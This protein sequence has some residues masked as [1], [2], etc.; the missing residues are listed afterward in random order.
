MMEKG[1]I[2]RTAAPLRWGDGA[3]LVDMVTK[4]AYREGFG[5]ELAEGS[6]RL[7]EKYGYPEYSM[8]AKKQEMPAYDPRGQQGIGLNYATSNRGGVMYADI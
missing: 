1:I 7:A 8:T 4:T 6:Y 2:P 5:D 3:V